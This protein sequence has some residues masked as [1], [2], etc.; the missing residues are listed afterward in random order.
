M[1]QLDQRFKNSWQ[2][3]QYNEF[4]FS[5]SDSER[6][7]IQVNHRSHNYDFDGNNRIDAEPQFLSFAS[8]LHHYIWYRY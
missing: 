3:I 5:L 6:V 2:E 8:E 4:D 7:E 1:K